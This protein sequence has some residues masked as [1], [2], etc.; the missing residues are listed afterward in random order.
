MITR[1]NGTLHF[2]RHVITMAAVLVSGLLAWLPATVNAQQWQYDMPC[3]ADYQRLSFQSIRVTPDTPVGATISDVLP[4]NYTFR[5]QT[6]GG[7]FQVVAHPQLQAS[8]TVRGVWESGT[9]GIGIRATLLPSG[10]VLSGTGI[11]SRFNVGSP[12]RAG[13]SGTLRINYQLVKTGRITSAV[14]HGGGLVVTFTFT[15]PQGLGVSR[16]NTGRTVLATSP[17][18][19]PQTCTVTT[20]NVSVPLPTVLASALSTSGASTGNTGFNIGLQCNTGANVYITLTDATTPGN[21]SNLLTLTS[22][23]T[24]RGVGIRIR[25]SDTTPV[26][27]GADSSAAGNTNQWRVGES[28]GATNIPMTAEYVANGAVTPGTVLGSATFTMSYQ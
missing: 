10:T 14:L 16:H 17:I 5:C 22:D 8:S 9:Y 24:A 25:R 28:S 26:S 7:P 3:P 4:V 15:Y 1:L 13:S 27:F 19:V 23:S 2:G 6:A 20:P 12:I 11:P 21:R 18:S